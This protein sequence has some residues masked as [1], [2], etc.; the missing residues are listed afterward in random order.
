M[1]NGIFQVLGKPDPDRPSKVA[2][3]REMGFTWADLEDESYWIDQ[4]V[5]M[6]REIYEELERA[7]A[8]LWL[9]LDKTVR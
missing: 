6:R 5:G 2:Q 3:L 4:I 7:S 8:Q 9:I 1:T